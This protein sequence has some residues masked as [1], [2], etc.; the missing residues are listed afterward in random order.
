M[1]RRLRRCGRYSCGHPRPTPEASLGISHVTLGREPKAARRCGKATGQA[2][3]LPRNRMY[4][5]PGPYRTVVVVVGELGGAANVKPPPPKMAP[6]TA[7]TSEE[8][9]APSDTA[10]KMMA[11]IP[12]AIA[13][14]IALEIRRVFTFSPLFVRVLGISAATNHHKQWSSLSLGEAWW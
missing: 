4:V 5:R 2:G 13:P 12:D 9:I 7:A 10:A 6:K 11:V 3:S 8:V 1:G 14:A